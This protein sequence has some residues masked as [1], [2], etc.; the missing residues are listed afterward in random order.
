M[1]AAQPPWLVTV[2]GLDDNPRSGTQE[3]ALVSRREQLVLGDAGC[4]WSGGD[5]RRSIVCGKGLAKPLR[6]GATV[7]DS[8]LRMGTLRSR[9]DAGGVA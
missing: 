8:G 4:W 7:R 1:P 9:D 3:C 6:V 2:R 5:E